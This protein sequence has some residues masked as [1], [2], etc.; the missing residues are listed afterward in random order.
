MSKREKT[1]GQ[2]MHRN[3]QK[4]KDRATLTPL[5]IGVELRCSGKVSSFDSTRHVSLETNPVTC[6]A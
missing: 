4:T 1:K 6:H 2:K 3:T 5:K